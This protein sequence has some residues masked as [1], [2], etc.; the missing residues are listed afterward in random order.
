MNAD[1]RDAVAL[2]ATARS[3]APDGD[4]RVVGL[5]PE[6]LDMGWRETTV[7]LPFPGRVADTAALRRQLV[8]WVEEARARGGAAP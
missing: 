2:Y 8:L 3:G 4:W 5:D 7:R 1:H 6:G